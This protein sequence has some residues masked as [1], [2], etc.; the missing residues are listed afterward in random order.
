MGILY[1]EVVEYKQKKLIK[2]LLGIIVFLIIFN[3]ALVLSE[4]GR[5]I[6]Y[7]TYLVIPISAF[8]VL[9]Q[10]NLWKKC[11]RKYRY[12][13]IDNELIIERFDRNRRKVELSINIKY[14]VKIERV[15]EKICDNIENKEFC[16][17]LKNT[18]LYRVI[19]KLDGKMYSFCFEPS[20]NFI[21]KIDTILKKRGH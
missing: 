11:N 8:L 1:R 17:S 13:I 5:N 19:Y 3:L 7:L 15:T 9:L 6:D 18:N 16:C 4:I 21:N 2:V 14:I 10:Y 12:Q 20:S